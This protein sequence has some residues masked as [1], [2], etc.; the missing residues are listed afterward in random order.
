MTWTAR[1]KYT[2]STL[3]SASVKRF[4]SRQ[5][6]KSISAGSTHLKTLMKCSPTKY[7]VVW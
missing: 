5:P 1:R 2:A 3:K 4:L 6:S 7:E